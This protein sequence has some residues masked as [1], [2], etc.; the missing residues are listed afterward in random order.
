M[1]DILDDLTHLH[2]RRSFL[3]LLQRQI[4]FA[5]ERH[6]LLALVVIDIDKFSQINGASGYAFGDHVLRHLAKQVAEVAR[7]QD[8]AARIGDNRFALIL[9]RVLNHGHAELAVQKL[10]RLLEVPVQSGDIRLQLSVSAG[11]AI[12]PSHATHPDFLMRKA[13][14][15]L[16][17]ARRDGRR[18][19]FAPDNPQEHT[20]SDLWDLE[21]E[22]AGAI[23]RGEMRIYFQPQVRIS[24]LHVVGAEA[25]MRWNSRSRGLISP[26]LF[27]PLA[28]RTGQIKQLTLWAMNT[29]LRRA[30]EWKHPWG[31]LSVA[32]NLPTELASQRDLPE[33]VENA[34]HLWGKEDVQL[35]LEITERSLMDREQAMDKLTRIRQMGVKISI[36]DFGTGYSCLAYFKNIPADELKIDKSFVAGL[37]TDTANADITSLI[38]EL[39]HRFGLDVVAEGVE[40]AATLHKLKS[41]GCDI[42]QGYLF[43]QA[44]PSAEFEAWMQT[45]RPGEGIEANAA[46]SD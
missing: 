46:A 26:D 25:L 34:M 9:P 43:G 40:N 41:G 22:M 10:F 4:T 20:I 36:D 18:Y 21:V 6:N 42:A 45:Y 44:M 19:L 2:N 8:Y 23:E 7:T 5:N 33:L 16:S 3:S 11:A 35:M 37:L 12:C 1:A 28:E 17:T 38:I 27:I 32:V 15:A 24:D 13:E 29:V 39:A 30:A 14:L 31:S